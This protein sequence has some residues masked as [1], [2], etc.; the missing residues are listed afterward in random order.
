MLNRIAT[1]ACKQLSVRCNGDPLVVS[2]CNC[3][4]CQRRTGS[5]FGVAAFFPRDRVTIKGVASAYRRVSDKGSEVIFSFCGTCGSTVYW[6][7]QRKPDSIAVAVG[8]F[9]E[10][11]F[12]APSQS[13]FEE[14][15]HAWFS[16]EL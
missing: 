12:P 8:C 4:E 6:E 2:L 5:A 13:V 14:H 3:L 11:E 15:K 1:C 9:A 16:L 7:P 10:P